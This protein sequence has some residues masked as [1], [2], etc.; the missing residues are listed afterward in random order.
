MGYDV[1]FDVVDLHCKQSI[2]KQWE[3]VEF[4]LSFSGDDGGNI[5]MVEHYVKW[6]EAEMLRDFIR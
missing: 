5:E 4:H 3:K 2:A 1:C 6:D